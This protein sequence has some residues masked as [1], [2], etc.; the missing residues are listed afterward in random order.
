MAS[1]A[2]VASAMLGG[3]ATATPVA[4]TGERGQDGGLG[5]CSPVENPS[6]AGWTSYSEMKRELDRLAQA[7]GGTVGVE[8]IGTTHRD[9]DIMAARVGTGPQV[10]VVT[11]AIH[12][13]ERTGVEAQLSLLK[14]LAGNSPEAKRIRSEVTFVSIPM[15]NPD[16]LELNRRVN[17]VSW[18][19]TEAQF[20]QLAGAT[21]AWY[22]RSGDLPGFDLNRDFH[23]H[24]DYVPQPEDMP[25]AQT[26]AGFYL[27]PESRAVRDLYVSLQEEFGSVAAVVDLH[28]MGPCNE[29]TGGPRDGKQVTVAIDYPPLGVNDGAA[30]LD[31]YPLLDQD[32]SRRYALAAM[33][34]LTD[35]YGAQ[36]PLAGVVR[37]LHPEEREF[38]GQGRSAFAL[39]GSAS[40]LFEVRGQ[41]QS[42]G[43][44]QKGMLVK[45]VETGLMSIIKAMADGSVNTLDGDDF[46][47]YP[48][49]GWDT[50]SG[51]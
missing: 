49:Y 39:N 3:P 27:N 51:D 16:G 40:V 10:I 17:D 5:T 23:P 11:G 42:F 13:N 28:D 35:S 34:G 14:T 4:V 8:S 24:L 44:K 18:A 19:D 50:A 37:Y 20:P 26:D 22:Y 43:Q 36:S 1:T 32:K 48:D 41:T 25:G 31:D 38:A 30:Y 45:T 29:T 7:S 9:R 15:L 6:T 12:G 33:D 2:L 21:P 47:D 46:F